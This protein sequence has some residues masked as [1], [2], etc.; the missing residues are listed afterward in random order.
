MEWARRISGKGQHAGSEGNACRET[1]PAKVRD[2]GNKEKGIRRRQS[3]E[4]DADLAC[5]LSGYF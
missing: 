5:K 1:D 2:S 3:T 4:A